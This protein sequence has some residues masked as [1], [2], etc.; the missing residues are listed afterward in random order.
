MFVAMSQNRR[1]N[2][3]SLSTVCEPEVLDGKDCFELTLQISGALRDVSSGMLRDTIEQLFC[4]RQITRFSTAFSSRCVPDRPLFFFHLPVSGSST[5]MECL[6]SYFMIIQLDAE[7]PHTQQIFIRSFP[8]FFFLSLG[9]YVWGN[10]H[11]TKDHRR[12]AF[13]AMPNITPYAAQTE[14]RYRYQLS[15]VISHLGNPEKD[16]GYYMTFLRIFGQWIRFNDTEVEAVE[17]LAALHDNFPKHEIL[18]N[19]HCPALCGR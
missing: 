4:F 17:E 7:P 13:P 1:I 8:R 18:S 6:N 19:C 16:Q 14:N 2:A 9:R 10:D 3:V 5:L 12:V 15:A 11:M